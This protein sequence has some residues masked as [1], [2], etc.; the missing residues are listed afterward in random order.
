MIQGGDPTG[1]G[2]G[3]PGYNFKDE[4]FEGEYVRGAVAMANSGP[5]TNGSQFFIVHKDSLQLPKSY[6]IFGKVISGMDVVDKIANAPVEDGGS[7]E[8]SK[9][10]SPVSIIKAEV[11]EE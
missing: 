5:D 10:L 8:V 1:T 11:I 2:S 4:P 6:V 9:P 7:G 3:G